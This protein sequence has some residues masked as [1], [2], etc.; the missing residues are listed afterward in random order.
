MWSLN[1]RLINWIQSSH[2]STGQTTCFL[3]WKR[4]CVKTLYLFISCCSDRKWCKHNILVHPLIVIP[5]HGTLLHL[6]EY[7]WY[8]CVH[9]AQWRYIADQSVLHGDTLTWA[10]DEISFTSLNNNSQYKPVVK[11]RITSGHECNH[12]SSGGTKVFQRLVKPLA[13]VVWEAFIHIPFV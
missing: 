9:T 12:K 2:F 4:V 1:F 6:S 5:F 8:V 7:M 13:E 10:H 3:Q 11:S